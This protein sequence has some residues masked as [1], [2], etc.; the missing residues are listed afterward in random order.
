MHKST[1]DWFFELGHRKDVIV[2]NAGSGGSDYGIPVSM[3]HYDL[4]ALPSIPSGK[5]IQGDVEQM[6]FS[7]G[8]FNAVLCVGSVLN[9]CDPTRCLSE[10]SRVLA[11]GGFAILE[12]E[13]SGSAEYIW[14]RGFASSAARFVTF[15][16][17]ES[18]HVWDTV[19]DSSTES[20]RSTGL[21]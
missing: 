17:R 2:L 18:T 13:R 14:Q 8:S 11:P 5:F 10:I 1:H 20:L 7:D 15:F 3:T 6:P 19:T 9:Y 12:Y 16:G 21:Q 4:M